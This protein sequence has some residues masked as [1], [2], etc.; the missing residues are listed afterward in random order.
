M[1]L[2]K[3]Q[4]QTV[5]RAIDARHRALAVELRSDAARSRQETFSA[6]AGTVIDSADESVADLLSDLNNAELSRDL[7]GLSA[8]EEARSR[9]AEGGFGICADCE[10]DIPFERLSAQPTA[11]R[12]IDCQRVHEKTFAHP[13]EPKL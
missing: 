7:A 11:L 10:A 4:L 1:A 6:I 12:C 5:R 8:L 2:T 9:L 3:Q 13:N